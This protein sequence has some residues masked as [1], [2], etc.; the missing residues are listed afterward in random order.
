MSFRL[1]NGGYK[2]SVSD[3]PRVCFYALLAQK[4]SLLRGQA[5]R[6]TV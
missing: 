5:C 1:L 3:M 4:D 2:D 6:K